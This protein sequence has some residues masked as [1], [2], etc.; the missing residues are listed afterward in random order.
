MRVHCV[1]KFVCTL[2]GE[3]REVAVSGAFWKNPVEGAFCR[4]KSINQPWNSRQSQILLKPNYRIHLS[5]NLSFLCS[6]GSISIYLPTRTFRHPHTS[7]TDLPETAGYHPSTSI[8]THLP[9][10]ATTDLQQDPALKR[11][12]FSYYP[13]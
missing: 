4:S 5:I 13:R 2:R 9:L 8:H 7:Q 3:L 12:R 6:L 1:I 11:K 10:Q